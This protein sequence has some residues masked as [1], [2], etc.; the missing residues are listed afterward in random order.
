MI[1]RFPGLQNGKLLIAGIFEN[2]GLAAV[3]HDNPIA[4]S[5]RGLVHL[6]SPLPQ[7]RTADQPFSRSSA[8]RFSTTTRREHGRA[9]NPA[10]VKCVMVR[11]TVSM[12]SPR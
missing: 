8:G 1:V 3:A 10:S 5:Y 11:E 7:S 6:F 4:V 9:M 12:V 2:Q